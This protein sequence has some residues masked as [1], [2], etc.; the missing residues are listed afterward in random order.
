MDTEGLGNKMKKKGNNFPREREYVTTYVI[1]WIP[2]RMFDA[3]E[4]IFLVATPV[5]QV[6]TA[7]QVVHKLEPS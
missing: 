4:V 3:A 5:C 2:P 1:R 6:T 7:A